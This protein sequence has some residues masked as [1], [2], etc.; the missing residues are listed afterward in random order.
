[1]LTVL[2]VQVPSKEVRLAAYT[3]CA[4]TKRVATPQVLIEKE[5]VSFGHK[6]SQVRE[7]MG[8]L[9]LFHDSRYGCCHGYWFSHCVYVHG[10]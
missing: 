6:F 10:R 2:Y 4:V 3:V 5:W 8:L 7:M 1:M 9:S